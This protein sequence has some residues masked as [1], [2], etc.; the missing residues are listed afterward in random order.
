MVRYENNINR[1]IISRSHFLGDRTLCS[2]LI[3]LVITLFICWHYNV[4]P[5]LHCCDYILSSLFTMTV[6]ALAV[7]W[8]QIQCLVFHQQPISAFQSN[9]TYGMGP[10][11]TTIYNQPKLIARL[12]LC[13]LFSFFRPATVF[14][15]P[16]EILLRI[17]CQFHSWVIKCTMFA[18]I[19]LCVQA[20]L[21]IPWRKLHWSTCRAHRALGISKGVALRRYV[22][23]IWTVRTRWEHIKHT[24]KGNAAI[25]GKLYVPIQAVSWSTLHL[26]TTH[27]RVL[28]L[29][30]GEHI[31]SEDSVHFADM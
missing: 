14:L 21:T 26:L 7:M 25:V 6:D 16:P 9:P 28:Q 10:N 23:A 17:A 4:R 22:L 5:K 18:R 20:K 29:E 2:G 13:H 31:R 3:G 24:V 1:R 19:A 27:S 12:Q 30:H 11:R 8:Y 15:P